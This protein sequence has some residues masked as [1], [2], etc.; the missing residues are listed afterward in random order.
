MP[1]SKPSPGRPKHVATYHEGKVAEANFLGAMQAILSA[2]KPSSRM[3]A[4]AYGFVTQQK[5]R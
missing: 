1:F 3:S 4:K 5:P 2:P